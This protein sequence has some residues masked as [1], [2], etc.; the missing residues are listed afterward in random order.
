MKQKLL[1]FQ[2]IAIIAIIIIGTIL[3]FLY[4]FSNENWLIG[5]FSA[6]NE[7][8][9]EHLKLAVFPII[10]VGIIEYFFIK[11]QANNFI[12]AKTIAI[13]FSII[14]IPTVF[15]VY[16]SILHTDVLVL[17]IAIFILSIIL[18]EFIALEIMKMDSFSTFNTQI[19]S[20]IIIVGIVFIFIL[21]TYKPPKLE[22]FKDPINDT[23]GIDKETKELQKVY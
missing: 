12:E 16:T 11:G 2:I 14:F 23:Y 13:I 15:Y 10:F 20:T 3:H 8:V 9:W 6:I 22:I 18:S 4:K 17:D 1:I 7:S 19:I 21:F 5:S